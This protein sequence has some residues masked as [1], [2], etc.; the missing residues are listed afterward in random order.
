M[1]THA[2]LMEQ[3]VHICLSSQSGTGQREICFWSIVFVI[4]K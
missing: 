3:F 2:Q 4:K 1:Y